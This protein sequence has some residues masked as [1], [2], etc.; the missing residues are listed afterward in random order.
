M[1][2]SWRKVYVIIL[3]VGK[4]LSRTLTS[5]MSCFKQY[6]SALPRQG[7]GKM[8]TLTKGWNQQY[9]TATLG[10]KIQ[11]CDE[12]QNTFTINQKFVKTLYLALAQAGESH[13]IRVQNRAVCCNLFFMHDLGRAATSSQCWALKYCKSPVCGCFLFFQ[14]QTKTHIS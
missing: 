1:F 11:Q 7:L 3:F 12:S 13:I 14:Q 8:V 10:K 9:D 5:L 6:K 4:N 2:L